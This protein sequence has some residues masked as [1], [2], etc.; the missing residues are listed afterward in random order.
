MTSVVIGSTGLVGNE[1]LK[2]LI[3][4]EAFPSI[5]TISRRAPKQ[6]SPKLTSVIEADTTKWAASLQSLSPT[7]S[8]VISALGTT[9]QLAGSIAAQWKIDHDLNVELAKAAKDMGVKTFVFVSSAGTRGFLASSAP[10]S[11]MKVG[12]E[13]TVMGL[14]FDNAVILRPGMILGNREVMH[15]GNSVFNGVVHGLG[16]ISTGLKDAC[17]QEAEV[18]ARAAMHAARVVREGKAEKNPWVLEGAD[19]MKFGRDEWKE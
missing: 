4:T 14:E 1:I 10:Y 11:K 13:D 9:R 7:P 3:A 2:T 12:V 18:I 16:K 8:V 6:T 19:I 17:G 15:T 5:H